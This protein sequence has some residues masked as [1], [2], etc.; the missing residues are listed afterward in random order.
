MR[1]MGYAD[2]LSVAGGDTVNFMISGDTGLAGIQIVRLH[3]VDIHS[4]K[5]Q[6]AAV[7]WT[8]PS[9]IAVNPQPLRPGSYAIID[10]P[11]PID[12]DVIGF[13]LWVQPTQYTPDRQSLLSA[14]CAESS[15]N[16]GLIDNDL[17]LE[18]RGTSAEQRVAVTVAALGTPWLHVVGGINGSTGALTLGCLVDGKW[19]AERSWMLQQASAA[20][21]AITGLHSLTFAA[22]SQ[23]HVGVSEFFN[24]RLENPRLLSRVPVADELRAIAAGQALTVEPRDTIAAW[25]FSADIAKRTIT[26]AGKRK[27]HGLLVNRPTRAV[28]GHAWSPA[29]FDYRGHPTDWAAIHF[30]EDDLDDARWETTFS[31]DIPE[32]APSGIYAARVTH[33]NDE[34]L[35]PFYVRPRRTGA[36][37]VFLAPTNTYLAYANEHLG[38]GE[39]GEAHQKMMR[40]PIVLNE[41]DEYVHAHA[42]LGL[43][44]YD[45]HSDG[46]GV[47]YSSW[48]RPVLNF[49]PDY[50]TWLN[51]GR[52]HFAADF[53]VVG[54]LESLGVSFDVMTDEDLHR[55]GLNDLAPYDV[56][57]T[58]THPEYPT[59]PELDA[60]EGFHRS[61]GNI[62]YLG[63]NGFYWVTAFDVTRTDVLECRRGFAA[64]RNWTSHPAELRYSSTA[65]PGGA[66]THNGRS[67]RLL[68]GV[69]SAGAGWGPASGFIRT[70]DS[71]NGEVDWVFQGISEEIIGD[72]GLILDGASGDEVDS[73]DFE[74]GTP[75]HAQVLLTSR[76][77]AEYYPFI[78][79][80]MAVEPR[81]DGA[82]NPNVRGDV[83]LIEGQGGEGSVFSAGSI[84]WAG[85]MAYNVYSNN[86]ARLTTN[87]LRRFLDDSARGREHGPC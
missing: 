12:S 31:L 28:L 49:R 83:V 79:T 67:S 24:G 46:S 6:R 84:C 56:L 62:M 76:H 55:G 53:Y 66:H 3:G 14:A 32:D 74:A 17:V 2:K 27:L 52:R 8:T 29:A 85:A 51:A 87:V 43:S 71:H 26:D 38:E 50:I 41:T 44:I 5:V 33:G 78:E 54:W 36:R 72:F 34:E 75:R 18:V 7:P 57:V 9:E 61:G 10:I 86:V 22:H 63:G 21:I 15:W 59:T 68:F 11:A 30:H 20:P 82:H 37:V 81:Q 1:L 16:L 70:E 35:L 13:D 40:D 69:T 65:E 77:G 73:V 64:Q 25:D 19:A 42:E 58:G 45:R 4:D 80:V 48:R 60:L 23:P 47:M 39:R